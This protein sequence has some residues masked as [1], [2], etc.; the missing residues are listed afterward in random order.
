MP[1]SAVT[2]KVG[3]ARSVARYNL[4]NIEEVRSFL[5]RLADVEVEID[6]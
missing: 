4:V 3:L 2:I 5:R 1:E 6:R